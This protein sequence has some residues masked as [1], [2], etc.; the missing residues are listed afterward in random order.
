MPPAL[1]P[2]RA[3]AAEW[4]GR[5]PEEFVQVLVAEYRPGTPLGWHRDVPDF[6][7]I[8]GISLLGNATMEFR[9]YPPRPLRGDPKGGRLRVAIAPRSLYLLSGASR[10]AWQHSVLPS[11]S[12]RY[13]I[14]LRTARRAD[15]PIISLAEH[16][17]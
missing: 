9:R 17:R 5:R 16:G 12:L 13:S 8:V 11:P 14:T 4:L 3:K 7:Q 10:W 2:L 6:E 15:Q 1:E